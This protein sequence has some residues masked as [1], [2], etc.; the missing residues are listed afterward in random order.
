VAQA[1]EH[2]LARLPAADLP[3]AWCQRGR[4]YRSVVCH[5]QAS[6]EAY[7]TAQSLLT[8]QTPASPNTISARSSG[9]SASTGT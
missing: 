4:Q 7:R 2:A 5:P 6:F 9:S 1:W 3:A 8:A